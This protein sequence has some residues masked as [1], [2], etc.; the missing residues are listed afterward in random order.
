MGI[1]DLLFQIGDRPGHLDISELARRL[2][3]SVK[4]LR[5]TPLEYKRFRIAK[6]SGGKR[7]IK[8]PNPNLKA[9]QRRILR[10]LLAK[11]TAHPAATGFERGES[12]ATNAVRH[13]GCEAV[14][15]L[16]IIDFFHNTTVQRIRRC[17]HRI[18]WNRNA[19][20]LLVRLCTLDGGLPQGAPTSPRL[21]N[22]V[23]YPIDIRLNAW[24]EKNN[25]NYSRYADDITFSFERETEDDIGTAIRLTR[26]VTK[27]YG[28]RI[29]RDRKLSIRRKHQRQMVT[30]L[31]VN[32]GVA[33]PRKTRRWLRAVEHRLDTGQTAS[34][35]KEQ[36]AG[37]RALERMIDL[38][39]GRRAK[40]HRDSPTARPPKKRAP[41]T[42]DMV[43]AQLQLAREQLL[44]LTMRNRL[45]NF[46]RT[47]RTTIRIIDELPGQLWELFV[48]KQKK[49]AFLA[50]E[51]HELF[52]AAGDDLPPTD[53]PGEEEPDE[54]AIPGD[55]AKLFHQP[56]PETALEDG[57]T[58]LPARYTDLFLQTDLRDEDLQ[59]NLLRID[60]QS[61]SALEERG[62]NLL[63]LA[64]GFL[65][66][67]P[68]DDEPKTRRA[69]L[70]LVPAGLE[71]ASARRRFKL[72]ALDDDPILN[73]CLVQKLREMGI[74]LPAEPQSWVDFD[75]ET[76]LRDVGKAVAEMPGWQVHEDVYLGFFSFTKYLMYLDLDPANWPEGRRLLE[77]RIL[78][79]VCGDAESIEQ[80]GS[81]PD[82]A[83]EDRERDPAETYQVLN[84]DSSQQKAI[85]AAREGRSI[86]IEGPPGTGKSQT[87]TNIIAEC[88]AAEKRVLFVSEK[89]AAL[90]VVK[91]RLDATGL[92]DFCLELHSTKAN[93]RNLATELG[94]VLDKGRR[95]ARDEMGDGERLRLLKRR[96][97]SLVAAVHDRHEPL[98]MSPYEAI[99]RFSLLADVPDCFCDIP[100][101]QDW[102]RG[103]LEE[104]KGRLDRLGRQEQNVGPREDHPWRGVRRTHVSSQDRRDAERHCTRLAGMLA[105]LPRFLKAVADDIQTP[106]PGSLDDAS[107]ALEAARLVADSPGPPRRLL[108][109]SEW[110]GDRPDRKAFLGLATEFFEGQD[111]MATR[112]REG[113]LNGVNWEGMHR[114]CLRYW[115]SPLRWFRPQYWSDRGLLKGF[116]ES[117]YRPDF[118]A[119]AAD[120]KRL[121]DLAK[122]K[123]EID[124]RREDG[125]RYFDE[126]W[127]GSASAWGRL[128]AMAD[129]LTRFRTLHRDGWLGDKAVTTASYAGDHAAT[130][131]KARA[132]GEKLDAFHSGLD[133]LNGLLDLSA[134]E[135]F[136]VPVLQVDFDVIESRFKRMAAAGEELVV[137]TQYQEA[138]QQCEDSPLKSFLESAME[139]DRPMDSS[140]R[141]LAIEKQFLRL[142]IEDCFERREELRQFNCGD[143][144][145]AILDFAKLDVDWI[146]QSRQRLHGRLSSRRPDGRMQAAP[147]SQMG[148]VQSEVRRKRGGRPI[149]KLLADA[150]DV[151]PRLKPCF[152]MSPLSVAQFLDPAGIDFDVVIFD[153]ASQVEPADALGAIARGRQL[154]LVGDPNQLPPT[155]FFHS[156][157]AP[158]SSADA[159]DAVGLVDMES[160]LDRCA[161]VLSNCRLRW[162]YRS[163]HESL[164]AFSNREFYDSRLVVFPSCHTGDAELGL[165]TI[166][167]PQDRYGRG[168]GQT[169]R[170]QAARVTDF[171]FEHARRRPDVS[172]GVGAFSR[173]QQQAILDE[174]EKRRI[175]DNSLEAFFD[176]NRP[177]PFFVKNLETIQGDERDVILLSVGYGRSRP[178]E[179]LSMNFGPLNQAGGW[180]RLNVLI[181]RARRQCVV[182]SSILGED[183]DLSATQA[184]GVHALKGYLDF[185]RDG[186]LPPTVDEAEEDSSALERAIYNALVAA[187]HTVCRR[188]GCGADAIDLAIEDPLRPGRYLLGIE[189]DGAKYRD[190]VTARDRD[191]LRQQVLEGYGWRIHRVWSAAWFLSPRKEMERLTA[192][193]AAARAGTLQAR[194]LPIASAATQ[195]IDDEMDLIPA[196]DSS[197]IP[198]KAY[199]RYRP[200]RRR[201]SERF[202]TDSLT[203]LAALVT[204]VVEVEGPVHEDQVSRR[205][206]DIYRFSRG[207]SRID[208]KISSAVRVAVYGGKI[209]RRGDFLWPADMETPPL[210]RRDDDD[211]RDIDLI[212]HAEIRRALRLLLETQFGMS[213]NDLTTQ[214][215]RLFGF[216]VSGSRIRDRIGQAIQGLLESGKVAESGAILNVSSQ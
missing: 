181:T 106:V 114:R 165:K 97:S 180:R 30:G 194:F 34:L 113:A 159:E 206:L 201:S 153:E 37:W 20:N 123:M 14:L 42:D 48:E 64:M 35:S 76:F 61:H 132:L 138:L 33:L 74:G 89:M 63:F 143:H 179:R 172:L 51:E 157:P 205:M 72:R 24:A 164:I 59:I 95:T 129:W 41:E 86:V 5:E 139:D 176:R 49:L 175:E 92:G 134:D 28:Y 163:R 110:E 93:R 190:T 154:I 182:F 112:Y 8:A 208:E 162:H 168:K 156:G 158:R 11:L 117:S 66:W 94:R 68:D 54:D 189:C 170:E 212:C 126:A 191:R 65:E 4:A 183:F 124:S 120:L 50:A 2:D 47:R 161:V 22:L 25:V 39:A 118:A 166:F 90:E 214:A 130:A 38:Q 101:W 141:P 9:V 200:R 192:V 108:L 193:I 196:D 98:G 186:M 55:L 195:E 3:M 210:R 71:R 203:E 127:Q 84:A 78:R 177:E 103:Q 7:T 45:L 169:N 99:G 82:V 60:Q 207:G 15:R 209:N 151:I 23:N 116:R 144:E 142:W 105:D 69:P 174:I 188:V 185:A 148:I 216:Q 122:L 173:R 75:T 149:R 145:A 125:I 119:Q 36:L 81:W 96:I 107:K 115:A 58:E 204:E 147:S 136:D 102:D 67:R 160:I 21:S 155:S 10:R 171:V 57:Q 184:R 79:T 40:T 17:F 52:Q 109:G 187:G 167:H 140:V 88:L 128:S 12:I 133:E 146:R 202:Y 91:R 100:G 150:A 178:A 199:R 73:P 197:P 152:M 46:Q 16:D 62:V 83:S 80:M 213:R 215:A 32:Q 211:I 85:L 18:G 121:A 27:E 53:E 198:V 19:A 6:R 111:W 56:R 70:V 31:V 137:W 1:L 26:T 29:H 77:N 44:D 135:M 131:K 87:I 43:R 104:M 13:T